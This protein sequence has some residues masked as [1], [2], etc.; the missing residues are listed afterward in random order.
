[1]GGLLGWGG[2]GPKGML[3]PPPPPLKLL[4][5]AALLEGLDPPLP[6]P[7]IC[8]GRVIGH[9]FSCLSFF[10]QVIFYVTVVW[11]LDIVTK[12]LVIVVQRELICRE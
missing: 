7:M 6:M 2:K 3:A 12:T 4:G 5:G 1:M 10:L 8:C 11:C 9:C